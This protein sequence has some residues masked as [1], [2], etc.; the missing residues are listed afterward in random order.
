M[1]ALA[2]YQG[3]LGLPHDHRV[4]ALHREAYPPALMLARQAG[5]GVLRRPDAEA[6]TREITAAD[7]VHLHFWNNPDL[8][9]L[10]HAAWPARR[11]LLWLKV[12]GEKPP[13]IVTPALV[14]YADMCVATSPHT[15]RLPAMQ[16]AVDTQ[17]AAM[18]YGIADFDRLENV[19]PRPHATFNVGYIGTVNFSKMHDRYVPMSARIDVPNIRFI[20][21]GNGDT[22]Q[23]LHQAAQLDAAE[24][25]IFNGFVEDIK[26]VMETLD[27]FGYPLC[28][29]TYATSEK[30]LQEAMYAGIPPVVFPYGGVQD[31]V[32]HGKTGLVVHTEEAYQEAITYLYDHPA[33]RVRLGNQAQAHARTHFAGTHAALQFDDLYRQML[34]RPKQQRSWTGLG[35]ESAAALRFVDALGE[36]APHFNSS[37][38]EQDRAAEQQIAHSSPLLATGEGGIMQYRNAYPDDAHLRFWCGLVLLRQQRYALAIR[39]L[40]AAVDLGLDPGRVSLYLDLARRESGG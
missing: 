2:K 32:E 24:K 16:S 40:M 11:L 13:Q 21:C 37:L 28:E 22:S 3:Q 33:E 18:V 39:E 14:D 29:D 5:I 27:V 10:L 12:L 1:I 19:T 7:I 9:G 8:Y 20:V 34:E 31:L 38:K 35:L 26:P 30:S 4:I 15:L 36:T 6:L 17:R 25:F 23:L